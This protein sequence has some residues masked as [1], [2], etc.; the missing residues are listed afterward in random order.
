VNAINV[1]IFTEDWEKAHKAI[2]EIREKE[3]EA[4]NVFVKAIEDSDKKMEE[5]K[6]FEKNIFIIS[7]LE[8]KLKEK[9][10]K[11]NDKMS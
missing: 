1:Y 4:L 10:Q 2:S 8:V 11:Y 9:E 6:R 5:K 3:K 7:K